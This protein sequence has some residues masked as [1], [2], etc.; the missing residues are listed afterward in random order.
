MPL[1]SGIISITK[2]NCKTI[3]NANIANTIPAPIVENKNGMDEGI[4]AARTQCTDDPN[5]CPEALKW[6]GKISDI[7]TH[8]TAPCPIA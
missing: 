7:N 8:I 6:F 2:S 4:I 1:V 5:D 3:I